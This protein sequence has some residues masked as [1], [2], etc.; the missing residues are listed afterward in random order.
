[1]PGTHSL[2]SPSRPFASASADGAAAGAAAAAGT[3][4]GT[5][6]A[7]GTA[8]AAAAAASAAG[9]EYSS[10]PL[11]VRRVRWARADLGPMGFEFLLLDEEMQKLFELPREVL[12][13]DLERKFEAFIENFYLED[14]QGIISPTDEELELLSR[15]YPGPHTQE[16]IGIG[17]GGDRPPSLY[18]LKL[19]R[20][21]ET[22]V[23]AAAGG[24]LVGPPAGPL[25]GPSGGPVGGGGGDRGAFGVSLQHIF[26]FSP[27]LYTAIVN[28]P[29]DATAAFDALLRAKPPVCVCIL[30]PRL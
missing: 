24:P 21:L 29:Q 14:Y 3:A 10:T 17:I 18:T 11:A 27:S 23:P 13:P 6:G 30:S 25:V 15:P 8:A 22:R 19:L 9:S 7:A 16:G 5:A 4:T 2:G 1:M 28:S 12:G 20:Y 26:V